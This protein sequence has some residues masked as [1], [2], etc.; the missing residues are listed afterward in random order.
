MHQLIIFHVWNIDKFKL[1]D[2]SASLWWY[3]DLCNKIYKFSLQSQ[4]YTMIVLIKG[5]ESNEGSGN[6]F[7][8]SNLGMWLCK[9][10]DLQTIKKILARI[11]NSNSGLKQ[12]ST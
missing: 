1:I 10:K 7:T 4:I 12:Q 9:A 3:L 2:L 8:F 5:V 6:R 11:E